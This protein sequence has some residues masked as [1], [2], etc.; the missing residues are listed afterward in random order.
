M[1]KKLVISFAKSVQSTSSATA[2]ESSFFWTFKHQFTHFISG[3]STNESWGRQCRILY[4]LA[5]C[6]KKVTLYP[7]SVK[8]VSFFLQTWYAKKKKKK[9]NSVALIVR[10]QL[11]N[12]KLPYTT[13]SPTKHKQPNPMTDHSVLC[14]YF[15][16]YMLT[17]HC[18]FFFFD[19]YIRGLKYRRRCSNLCVISNHIIL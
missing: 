9:K 15:S 18:S 13:E 11:V 14:F 19:I 7:V 1:L 12:F 2:G 8:L 6:Y 5:T 4:W 17:P 10:L 16:W 3:I